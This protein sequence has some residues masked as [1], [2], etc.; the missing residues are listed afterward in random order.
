VDVA[1]KSITTAAKS[2]I[3]CLDAPAKAQLRNVKKSPVLQVRYPCIGC[4]REDKHSALDGFAKPGWPWHDF[5]M[6]DYRRT[7]GSYSGLSYHGVWDDGMDIQH[8]FFR[9]SKVD[10]MGHLNPLPMALYMKYAPR[11]RGVFSID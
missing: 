1:R 4:P 10:S 7:N 6:D 5:E 8:V 3:V 9:P 11:R 2:Y